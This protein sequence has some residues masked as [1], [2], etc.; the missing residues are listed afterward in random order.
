M[1]NRAYFVAI[2]VIIADLLWFG[3]ASGGGPAAAMFGALAL[4]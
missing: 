1:Y 2:P 3:P 4:V